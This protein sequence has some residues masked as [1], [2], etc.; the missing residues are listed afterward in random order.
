MSHRPLE[1]QMICTYIIALAVLAGAFSIIYTAH[2]DSGQAWLAIGTVLG[3]IFRDSGGASAVRNS[4]RAA[5]A[6][7][8]VTGK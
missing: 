8:A 4:E 3:Y 2:G 5:A 1:I 7:N 6:V